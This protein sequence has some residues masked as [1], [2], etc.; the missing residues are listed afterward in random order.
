MGRDLGGFLFNGAFQCVLPR[1]IFDHFPILLDGG[2]LRRGPSLFRF[3]NMWLEEEGFDV[4]SFTVL[5]WL[6]N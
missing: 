3:E 1:P 5:F 4:I 2:G 6:L